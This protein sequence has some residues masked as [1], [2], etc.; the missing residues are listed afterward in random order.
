MLVPLSAPQPLF[1]GVMI[2]MQDH[3][4]HISNALLDF[5]TLDFRAGHPC[6]RPLRTRGTRLGQPVK[7]RAAQAKALAALG[8][9]VAVEIITS[10][11]A[12]S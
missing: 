11:L 9:A 2:V 10:R 7:G 12:I 5:S 4:E 6:G 3:A 1:N 8:A